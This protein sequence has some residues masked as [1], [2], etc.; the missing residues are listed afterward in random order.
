M[1]REM[2]GDVY[3]KEI[4]CGD[5]NAHSSL[6][7]SNHTDHNGS[8]VEELL[9]ERSLI[10]VNNGQGT[11]IDVNRGTTSCLDLTLVSDS[12]VN[13]CDWSIK[14]NTTVGSDH[15]PIVTVVNTRVHMQD[16]RS[17]TRWCF[18]K[19]DWGKFKKHCEES[20]NLVT[21]EGSVEQCASEVTHHIL[22]AAQLYIPKKTTQGNRKAV[23]WWNDECSKAVKE[24]N[25]ALRVLRRNLSQENVL[26]Y[27]R[28]RAAARK[29]IKGRKK[30][31]WREF[32]SSIGRGVELGD[33]WSMF[34]RMSGKR[35]TVKIPALVEGES[36]MLE[37]QDKADALGRAFAAVHS[38]EH[39]ED[40]HRQGKENTLRENGNVREKRERETDS[41][42]CR[43]YNRR[44]QSCAARHWV[45]SPRA[46]P[47][48]LCHVPSDTS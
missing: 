32:C 34:K 20:V 42:G 5:F 31:T 3:R 45:H 15:F 28:K 4:W 35:T 25:K 9:D 1:F 30:E 22:E 7:G 6:W 17:F 26:D 39:L 16:G 48:L 23:P 13:A 24:R 40:K 12:L 21:L 46:R 10:C 19:A 11:R 29:I 27:Q 36:L 47:A 44:A 2:A 8:A 37:D 18:S 33:V 43:Y 14:D 38:G 41:L